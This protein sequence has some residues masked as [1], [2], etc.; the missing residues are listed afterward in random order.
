MSAATTTVGCVAIF[1]AVGITVCL[2][3]V[4]YLF[5]DIN[6]FYEDTIGELVLFQELVNTAWN[7]MK[8]SPKDAFRYRRTVVERDGYQSMC[9][10]APQPIN[11]PPGPPGPPGRSGQ[12][13]YDG[14]PGKPGLPGVDG[15]PHYGFEEPP[16]CIKCPAGP[17]GRRGPT[18]PAG[19]QGY[20]GLPGLRGL[21]GDVGTPGP[22]GPVG[23][24][25]PPGIPGS[26]GTPGT[27]GRSVQHALCG[28]GPMGPMGRPGVPGADGP[29]GSE[30]AAGEIGPPGPPGPPGNPG[31]P[32]ED[33]LPGPDGP[34]GLPGTDADYCKCPPSSLKNYGD[35]ELPELPLQVD[36]ADELVE[37]HRQRAFDAKTLR[38]V[39]KATHS[40]TAA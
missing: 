11:C 3:F 19:L 27:A 34:Q 25:G 28:P 36:Y 40:S 20:D 22:P 37:V 10:C 39:R 12:P 24:Q 5:N 32:G 6:D 15:P 18:G 4:G 7:R 2:L 31:G 21:D 8:P 1:V 30:A 29:N 38:V 26:P 16:G 33:G 23:D 9:N 13:G 35:L 17:P 14:K